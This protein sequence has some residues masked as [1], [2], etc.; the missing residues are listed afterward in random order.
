VLPYREWGR[1]VA[2]DYISLLA[3]KDDLP[4]LDEVFR[5]VAPQQSRAER[6]YFGE[7]VIDPTAKARDLAEAYGVTLPEDV[8]DRTMAEVFTSTMNLPVVGDR[9][10]LGEIE[11]VVRRMEGRQVAELGLRLPGQHDG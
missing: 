4:Q 8:L 11:V 7:F 2:G 9:L 10:R 6:E 3:A 1:F 5:R